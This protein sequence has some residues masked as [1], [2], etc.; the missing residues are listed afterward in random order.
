MQK[1]KGTEEVQNKIKSNQIKWK[2]SVQKKNFVR[3]NPHHDPLVISGRSILIQSRF[4]LQWY[5]D[6]QLATYL[7]L[8]VNKLMRVPLQ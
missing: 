3:E 7:K 5:T 4:C 2:E 6:S 8:T 1:K